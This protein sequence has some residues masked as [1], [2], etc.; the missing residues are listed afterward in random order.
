MVHTLAQVAL[1]GAVVQLL[2]ELYMARSAAYRSVPL[3]LEA[4]RRVQAVESTLVPLVLEA[5]R[6]V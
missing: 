4:Y 6:R 1:A 2:L 5:Y 3:A